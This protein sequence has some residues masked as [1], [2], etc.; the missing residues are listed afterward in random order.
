MKVTMW[1]HSEVTRIVN[2]TAT[3]SELGKMDRPDLVGSGGVVT[4]A[5]VASLPVQRVPFRAMAFLTM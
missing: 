1:I 5:D 4:I 3:V 2:L